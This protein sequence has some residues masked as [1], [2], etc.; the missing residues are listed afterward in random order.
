MDITVR[1]VA[2]RD[3]VFV[4][5]L[6][7]VNVEVLSPMDSAKYEYFR[8]VSEMFRVVEA[9]GE[10]VAFLIALR[11][12]HPDYTSENYIWFSERYETFLYVD[13]IVIDEKARHLGI[14]RRLYEE[15]FSRAAESG[16][17]TVTAE[18]D[19]IPYNGPSLQFHEAMGFEEVGR[20]SIR[21][22]AIK[23]SLEA[24]KILPQGIR[25]GDMKIQRG[26]VT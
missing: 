22:G 21:G 13:R 24:R 18:I 16:V 5:E 15:V 2:P 20:Q 9:D 6:N 12:G 1:E 10:P 3:E 11:E 23:V 7:R 25:D 4:L 14:G 19:I 26:P 17:N 8:R